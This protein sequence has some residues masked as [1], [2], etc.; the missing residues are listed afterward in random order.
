MGA[1]MWAHITSTF[2]AK[3]VDLS[4][5]TVM[6]TGGNAGWVLCILDPEL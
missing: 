3:P 6:V 5:R 4:G 2:S 1:F